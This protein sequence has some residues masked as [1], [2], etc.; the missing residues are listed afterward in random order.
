MRKG[1]IAGIASIALAV[2]ISACSDSNGCT[3]DQPCDE[4]GDYLVYAPYWY[5][6]PMGGPGY[7]IQPGQPH[8]HQ[9]FLNKPPSYTPP[10]RVKPPTSGYKPPTAKAPSAKVNSP[11]A[12]KVN[13]P[14]PVAPKPVSP[15]RVK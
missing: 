7:W 9:T 13:A 8:Y 5:M 11:S 14:K 6:P 1:V 12:P 15:P 10:S 4:N 3:E 2:G